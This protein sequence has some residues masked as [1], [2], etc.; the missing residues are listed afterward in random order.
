MAQRRS[1]NLIEWITE[2]RM[3]LPIYQNKD[4]F[5][6]AFNGCNILIVMGETGSGKTT[7]LPQFLYEASYGEKGIIGCTLPRYSFNDYIMGFCQDPKPG[8]QVERWS[9]TLLYRV[10]SAHR[11]REHFQRFSQKSMENSFL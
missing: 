10:S 4:Q 1:R 7:Q 3:K 11:K 2:E 9:A 8:D 5:L 6:Q